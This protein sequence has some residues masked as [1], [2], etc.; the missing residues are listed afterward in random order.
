LTLLFTPDYVAYTGL[1]VV[2]TRNKSKAHMHIAKLANKLFFLLVLC[3]ELIAN[4]PIG[5]KEIQCIITQK[6]KDRDVRSI[7]KLFSQDRQ[8][9]NFSHPHIPTPSLTIRGN[10]KNPI[11]SNNWAG[12]VAANNLTSPTN[13]TVS[14][15]SGSWIVPNVVAEDNPTYSAIWVGIDGYS[16]S[17]VE[18]IGTA[19]DYV[20]GRIQHYAWFEMHPGSS[21]NITGF[22]VHPGDVISASVVYSGSGIF[23]MQILNDTQKVSYTVPI[24]YTTSLTAQRS[25]AEWIIE[26]PYMNTILPLSNFGTTYMWG[27]FATINNV[28]AP[29][30]NNS[31][32]NNSLLMI[33]N[34]NT[35]KATS[36]ALLPD[37]G[38]FFTVWQHQ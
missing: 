9:N 25:C 26:A 30:K 5:Y 28:T 15:V 33:T 23:T 18:Q 21:Y 29:I 27:C 31:W 1:I 35:P 12:Y 24:S 38:S 3:N 32:Q 17:T 4:A 2:S 22:P 13:N 16:N 8:I 20:G 11:S 19:H 37:N 6:Q 36:S 14:A 10:K 7:K 34:N